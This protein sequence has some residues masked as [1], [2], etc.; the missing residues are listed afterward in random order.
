MLK[1]FVCTLFLVSALMPLAANATTMNDITLEDYADFTNSWKL[2]TVRYRQDTHEMRFTYANSIAWNALQKA[3][4][5]YPDGSVFA[6]VGFK[7]GVD[8]AFTSSIVPN[9][10][11]RFQFIVKSSKKYTDTDGWGYALFESDGTAA[12]GDVKVVTQSCHACH[13]LVEERNYVFSE[14]LV[15]SPLVKNIQAT[16]EI[17]NNSA[18]ILF[19]TLFQKQYEGQLK[20]NI[21]KIKLA[22]LEIVGGDLRR[23]YFDGT[24]DEI[25]P[26]LIK[27]AIVTGKASAFVSSDQN[28]FKIIQVEK[29]SVKSK[30]SDSEHSLTATEYR[31]SWTPLKKV[32]QVTHF[33]YAK[34]NL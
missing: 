31:D 8:P 20:K 4:R 16:Y 25:T 24:L 34:G 21:K 9:G 30:C 1:A 12:E 22:R 7:S 33:C 28:T 6:K 32:M 14:P 18:H 15:L 3:A 10:A 29:K 11:R 5:V 13:K 26:L 2:V 19:S 23:F 27:N 17:K